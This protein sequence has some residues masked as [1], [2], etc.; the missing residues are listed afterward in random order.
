MTVELS[1]TGGISEETIQKETKSCQGTKAGKCD[2]TSEEQSRKVFRAGLLAAFL[3]VPPP[4]SPEP[5]T[6]EPGIL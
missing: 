5:P 4:S 3:L 2:V 6:G 1:R